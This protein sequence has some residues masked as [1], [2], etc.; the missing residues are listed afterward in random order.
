[1]RLTQRRKVAKDGTPGASLQ[2]QSCLGDCGWTAFFALLRLCVMNSCSSTDDSGLGPGNIIRSEIDCGG[3]RVAWEIFLSFIF[4]SVSSL[5]LRA[6]RVFR[7][8]SRSAKP[9][10]EDVKG[11]DRN[12]GMF[13]SSARGELRRV[14]P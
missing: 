3:G 1:M 5:I 10:D 7:G 4:L 2:S 6:L 8:F 9:D 12:M 14:H 13:R 11:W